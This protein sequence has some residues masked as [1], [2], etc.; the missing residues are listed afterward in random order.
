M[1]TELDRTHGLEALGIGRVGRIHW[2]LG[3]AAL[4]EEALRRR[5]GSLA[6]D[7]PLVCRTGQHTGRSPND[8]FVVREDSS[9]RLIHWGAVNRAIDEASFDTLHRDM[10]AYLENKDLFVLDGWA[11]TDAAFAK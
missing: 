11:G 2:N 1:A 6:A 4:Y 3:P 5:E 7:G 9:E 8:K 10:L